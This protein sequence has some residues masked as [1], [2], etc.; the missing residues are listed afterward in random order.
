MP[1]L[2][3]DAVDRGAER[4][5]AHPAVVMGD[6]TLSYAELRDATNR[7]AN[8][9]IELG[10][11]PGDRV[12]LYLHKSIETVVTAYGIM[13]AGCAFV[14]IDP[15][16]PAERLDMILD[17]CGISIVVTENRLLSR[18]DDTTA[19]AA[20]TATIG[21]DQKAESRRSQLTWADVGERSSAAPERTVDTH[22]LA[23]LMYTSGS[24][25]MPKGMMHS[26]HTSLGFGLWG[27]EYCQ[28]VPSDR[29][30]S[31][32]PLHFDISIFD[33]FSTGLAGATVVLVPEAVTKFPA[34]FAKLLEEQQVSALFTVP[35]ALAQLASH[36][37]LDTR[38]L[39]A[40][41][42]VLF[43]GEPF[44]PRHLRS[45]MEALPHASFANVYG[46]AEAPA[47]VCHVVSEPPTDDTPIPI[48]T[49]SAN[50]TATV[51]AD[52]SLTIEAQSV[53]LG[54]W[55]RPE[56]NE[57]SLVKPGVF[58]TGDLV[59]VRDDG[60]YDFLGRSDRMVKTRGFRVE[61]DEVEAALNAHGDIAEAATF[62][63]TDDEGVTTIHAA[64]VG[65]RELAVDDVR[66][67]LATRLPAYAIPVTLRAE[68]TFP[69]TTSDKID[70]SALAAATALR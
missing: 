31:H 2:V 26:H 56:L 29:V 19:G 50:T 33:I 55:N 13:K 60:L 25:G 63:V 34:S 21:P 54:Y 46:P 4:D 44:T 58:R 40:L 24:T 47:C 52:G 1:L 8:T 37:A 35:F 67:H 65:A 5:P 7:L 61:L 27:V 62:A 39:T 51:E 32:G 16:I 41:R 12:G 53:T 64:F 6:A 43:G 10:A 49:V 22:D 69:R 68:E 11:Q 20:I 59:R 45:L 14:P 23:Y 18:L 36:G 17:D 48:G 3:H 70:R 28:L 57:R 15:L 42:W 9:L 38:D 30:A 66:A